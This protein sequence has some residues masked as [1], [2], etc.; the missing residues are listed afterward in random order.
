MNRRILALDLGT[1]L[2]WALLDGSSISSGE[3]NLHPHKNEGPG[4]RLVRFRKFLDTIGKVDA[5]YYES[6]NRHMGTQAAHVYGSLEGRLQEWCEDNGIT[7]YCGIP[8]TQIKKHATGKG[9]ADKKAMIAAA[10][11]QWP[12]QNIKDTEDNRSDSLWVLDC[13]LESMTTRET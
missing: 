6:V 11:K 4:M 8:V 1:K 10:Q 13:A 12:E 3:M 5:V 2:G 7:E 9:N